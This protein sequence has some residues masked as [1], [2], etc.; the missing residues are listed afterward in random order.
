M[1][2]QESRMCEG[3]NPEKQA[4]QCKR[5]RQYDSNGKVE[6]IKEEI[7]G[8]RREHQ[9]EKKADK[10][11]S[12]AEQG[13]KK[14]SVCQEKRKCPKFLTKKGK[15]KLTREIFLRMKLGSTNA[16]PMAK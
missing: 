11:T 4:Q 7:E 9:E 3:G 10:H 15:M 13:S 8:E 12:E 5:E 14:V 1:D 2:K 16:N 6:N